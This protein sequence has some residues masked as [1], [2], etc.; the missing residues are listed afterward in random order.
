MPPTLPER[1][2]GEQLLE[3]LGPDRFHVA[4]AINSID[5]S[6]DPVDVIKQMV[7]VIRVGGTVWL[8]HRI[9]EGEHEQ[10]HGLHQWNFSEDNGRFIIWKHGQRVDMTDVPWAAVQHP[11]PGRHGVG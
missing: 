5:H 6:Y 8:S 1:C 9:N 3:R 2:D 7:A 10:Y 4:V 11:S